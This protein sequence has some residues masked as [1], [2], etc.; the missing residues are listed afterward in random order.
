MQ[1]HVHAIVRSVRLLRGTRG[2][3]KTVSPESIRAFVSVP[4]RRKEA[5]LPIRTRGEAG[6]EEGTDRE[7]SMMKTM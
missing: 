2:D 4:D 7:M 1:E 5:Q 3:R 6:K